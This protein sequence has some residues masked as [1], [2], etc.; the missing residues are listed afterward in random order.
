MFK[1]FNRIIAILSNMIIDE[2]FIINW[3]TYTSSCLNY[4]KMTRTNYKFTHQTRKSNEIATW[5]YKKGNTYNNFP[6]ITERLIFGHYRLLIIGKLYFEIKHFR[7]LWKFH[8]QS[9]DSKPQNRCKFFVTFAKMK[10]T[11]NEPKADQIRCWWEKT[12]W[13]G[14]IILQQKQ[15]TLVEKQ[16]LRW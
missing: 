13:N 11:E 7:R 4:V 2:L 8:S 5:K 16:G 3:P 9:E 12:N 15:Q 14:Y 6:I 1:N 10:I